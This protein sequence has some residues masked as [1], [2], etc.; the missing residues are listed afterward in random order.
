MVDKLR[1][2][3]GLLPVKTGDPRRHFDK[4]LVFL[5]VIGLPFEV[6]KIFC[7][8]FVVHEQTKVLVYSV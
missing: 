8:R 3:L 5:N 2:K 7:A 1:S 4:F 6:L